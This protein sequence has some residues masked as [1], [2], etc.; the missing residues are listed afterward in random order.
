M[1]KII[2]SGSFDV[3]YALGNR[4]NFDEVRLDN[5][6]QTNSWKGKQTL[7]TLLILIVDWY[8]QVQCMKVE[9]EAV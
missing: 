1:K 2:V 4:V 9:V 6:L 8:S 5:T 3:I 7:F